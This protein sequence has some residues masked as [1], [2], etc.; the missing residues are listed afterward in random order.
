M[1]LA[2]RAPF[3]Q[4]ISKWIVYLLQ[5]CDRYGAE[6]RYE[7][8]ANADVIKAENPDVVIL[9]TGAE[10]IVLPVEGKETMIQANDVL[11]GKVPILGGNAAIIGGGMVGIE[12]AEY[13]L[14]HSR[15]AARAALIEMTDSIGFYSQ[16]KKLYLCI[17]E[18]INDK[19]M[20]LPELKLRRDKIRSL[21]AQ[22]EID[23]ALIACN[24]NLIYTYGRVVS[25]Y[26]YLP[27]NAPARLFIKRPN[28]IEGEHIH[29]IR[30]PEQL[31]DLL[32]ECGLPIP[33]RLMLE[34]S[35]FTAYFL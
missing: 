33:A 5:E 35:F 20:L 29:P 14:H 1:N 21:M 2:C 13:V 34:E 32:K 9:A 6:I 12:T 18:T 25:G 15:G 28:N 31:P 30:K 16:L 24:V 10:P 22:Q 3:K 23:A 26:L 4:E 7:T 27:L 8:E 19:E 17:R 11:S